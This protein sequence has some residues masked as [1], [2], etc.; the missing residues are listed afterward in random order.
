MLQMLIALNWTIQGICVPHEMI[1]HY[2]ITDMLF[3]ECTSELFVTY[4]YIFL[5]T[6]H[7][8]LKL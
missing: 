4:F 6:S 1:E 7:P 8:E 3:S 2:H 5:I